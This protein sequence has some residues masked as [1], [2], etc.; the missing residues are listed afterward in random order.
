MPYKD[1][2][3][4]R[5]YSRAWKKTLKGQA[6]QLRYFTGEHGRRYFKNGNLRSNYDGFTVEQWDAMFAAQGFRCLVCKID[7]P[8]SIWGWQTHHTGAKGNIKVHGILCRRCN[9]ALEKRTTPA[10]LRALA[11]FMETYDGSSL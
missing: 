8:G 10:I 6:C 5:A 7:T 4:Q 3:K 11:D 1:K 9:L 2:E